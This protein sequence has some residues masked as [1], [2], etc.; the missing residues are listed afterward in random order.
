MTPDTATIERTETTDT[1]PPPEQEQPTGT[2]PDGKTTEDTTRA[3]PA[4]QAPDATDTSPEVKDK[5]DPEALR[6]EG[7]ET[8][9]QRIAR[10]AAEADARKARETLETE[11]KALRTETDPVLAEAEDILDQYAD[12]IPSEVTRALRGLVR[13]LQ[14]NRQKLNLK[15][16]EAAK[17]ELGDLATRAQEAADNAFI[18]WAYGAIDPANTAAFT[19]EVNNKGPEVWM[20]AVQKYGP[21]DKDTFGVSD[22]VSEAT[23][24]TSNAANNLDDAEKAALGKA[25]ESAKTPAAVVKAVFDAG[26]RKGRA[27]PEGAPSGDERGASNEL[28]YA[29]YVKLPEAEKRKFNREH[30]DKFR[31][32]LGIGKGK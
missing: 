26:R 6:R 18:Q 20:K 10:E 1:S 9:R 7:A 14:A 28:S 12:S 15:S 3:N 32:L 19:A 29:D 22:L 17:V 5:I 11:L 31:K 4:E 25:L 8:E 16:L 24:L 30:P 21:K 27:D 13:K 2:L 23:T